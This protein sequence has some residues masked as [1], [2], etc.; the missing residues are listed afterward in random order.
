MEQK[1]KIQLSPKIGIFTGALLLGLG[2][3]IIFQKNTNN[4][5]L[6]YFMVVYGAFRLGL[7]LYT[8]YKNKNINKIEE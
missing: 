6:A 8:L 1:Q 5:G 3:F 2:L 4:K 7:S